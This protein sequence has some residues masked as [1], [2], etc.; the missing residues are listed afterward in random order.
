M[1]VHS[2]KSIDSATV[3]SRCS[4][5]SGHDVARHALAHRRENRPRRLGA[6][7]RRQRC[8]RHQAELLGRAEYPFGAGSR[9]RDRRQPDRASAFPPNTSICTS[10]FPISLPAFITNAIVPQGVNIA[11]IE[12][13][14]GSILGYDPKTY[15]EVDFFGEDDTRSNMIRLV[16]ERF[17]KI[18]NVPNMK[19]HGAAG[20]TGCLKNIAYGELL[21][22]GALASDARRPTRC[23]SSARSPRVEPL[24][25]KTVL[26]VMD[27]LRGVWHGGPFSTIPQFRF[28]PKQIMFGTDPV[29]IDRLLI[30]SSRTSA[31]RKARSRSGTAPCEHQSRPQTRIP[32]SITS[33][34]SPAI[35]STPPSWA[36]AFTTCDDPDDEHRI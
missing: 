32:T 29:A 25:S 10:V 6:L 8:R 3:E 14:R 36:W 35:S 31:K 18:I 15:V 28:Y 9:G 20:V 7:L 34:A 23:R 30:D 5:R 33:S 13:S 21:E 19:D 26:Q 2:E 1:R 27:G 24:R 11:A 16:T 22:R 4:D 12:M 17:T